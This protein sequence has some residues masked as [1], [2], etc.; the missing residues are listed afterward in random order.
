MNVNFQLLSLFLLFVYSAATTK[1]LISLF[2]A[3]A[4]L[5]IIEKDT[6]VLAIASYLNACNP[7]ASNCNAYDPNA[8]N[9]MGQCTSSYY[10]YQKLVQGENACG[11]IQPSIWYEHQQFNEEINALYKQLHHTSQ[12]ASK[13][14]PKRCEE[15]Q[16]LQARIGS[17]QYDHCLFLS[18][19]Q[20]S[21]A[22]RQCGSSL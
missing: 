14:L 12:D 22:P 2:S 3:F 17:I 1:L 4:K 10:W 19:A 9:S 6:A 21:C 15:V 18:N 20:Y 11:C 7:I 8:C 5:S 16:T 13:P